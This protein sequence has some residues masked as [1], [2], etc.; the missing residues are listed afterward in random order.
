MK[1]KLNSKTM[2]IIQNSSHS[3]QY[4]HADDYLTEKCRDIKKPKSTVKSYQDDHVHPGLHEEVQSVF[5][6]LPRTNSSSAQ[7][8]FAGV[9]GGQ[10]IVSVLLQ[11]SPRDDGDQ[12][13]TVVHYG[14]LA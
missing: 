7:Q 5:V 10:R 6:V 13:I 8:L 1:M 11:V 9:L 14:E 12:L 2:Y 4:Q 3:F